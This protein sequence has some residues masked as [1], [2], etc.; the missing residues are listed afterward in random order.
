M[1]EIKDPELDAELDRIAASLTASAGLRSARISARTGVQRWG[2]RAV[3]LLCQL[4]GRHRPERDGRLRGR[5]CPKCGVC[6][7]R[8]RH[9]VRGHQ[10]EANA[11]RRAHLEGVDWFQVPMSF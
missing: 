4:E 8:S 2:L 6:S 10:A 5:A 3:C 7:L 1:E 9:W 11:L